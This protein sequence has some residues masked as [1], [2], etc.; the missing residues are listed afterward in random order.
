VRE[1]LAQIPEAIATG[2]S[3]SGATCFALFVDR[4]SATLA[5]RIVATERPDWWV[6][7]TAIG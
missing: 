2:M 3:G 7:A 4:R 5:R 6:V 1:R